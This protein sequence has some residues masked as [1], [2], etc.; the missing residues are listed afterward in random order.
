MTEKTAA[1]FM[2]DPLGYFDGSTTRMHT[3]PARS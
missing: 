1:T 2:N 3:F